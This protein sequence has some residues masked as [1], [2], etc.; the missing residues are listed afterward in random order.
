MVNIAKNEKGNKASLAVTWREAHK[1]SAMAKAQKTRKQKELSKNGGQN[2][3]WMLH[4]SNEN[5]EGEQKQSK[6]GVAGE[7]RGRYHHGS[8]T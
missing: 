6:Q 8:S 1:S 7:K 3:V 4:E 2:P 5:E